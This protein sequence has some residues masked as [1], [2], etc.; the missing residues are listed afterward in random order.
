AEASRQMLA[1]FEEGAGGEPAPSW[2]MAALIRPLALVAGPGTASGPALDL[3]LRLLDDEFG[4]G[5][6]VRF[7]EVDFPATLTHEPTRRFLRETGLPED[8]FLFSL[9][10]DQP[11]RT[12][13]EYAAD[14]CGGFPPGLLPAHADRLIRVG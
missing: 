8:G 13:T 7:E 9:D 3:A 6:V 10:T 11:L 4:R 1:V 2:R 12:L 5:G 14:D